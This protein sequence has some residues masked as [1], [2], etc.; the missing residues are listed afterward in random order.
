MLENKSF[1][2]IYLTLK[3]LFQC[4]Y[5]IKPLYYYLFYIL[6]ELLCLLCFCHKRFSLFPIQCIG[7]V[8]SAIALCTQNLLGLNMRGFMLVFYQLNED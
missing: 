2:L 6:D 5:H 1:L 8:F 3:P 7:L 4:N